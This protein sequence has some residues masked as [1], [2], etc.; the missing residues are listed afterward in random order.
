MVTWQGKQL[1][2]ERG[3]ASLGRNLGG[4]NGGQVS[5]LGS[6]GCLCDLQSP[7]MEVSWDLQEYTLPG[8]LGLLG[9]I[10]WIAG[11]ASEGFLLSPECGP[12]PDSSELFSALTS[13]VTFPAGWCQVLVLL[14]LEHAPSL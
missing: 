11:E 14:S 10:L 13:P 1:R 9:S 2:L 5:G 7:L 6:P 4:G 12:H 8:S 3:Q